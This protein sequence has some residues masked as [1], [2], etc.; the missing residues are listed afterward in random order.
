MHEGKLLCQLINHSEFENS[1]YWAGNEISGSTEGLTLKLFTKVIEKLEI[2]SFL[3][4]GAN[5]GNFGFI[6]LGA[7]ASIREI[8]F[9]EP[10]PNAF[11]VLYK[12]LNL[13]SSLISEKRRVLVLDTA[14]TDFDGVSDLYFDPRKDMQFSASLLSNFDRRNDSSIQ[15]KCSQV[16]TLIKEHS[17]LPPDL[18]KLDIEGGEIRALKGFGE[19]LYNVK[20][21]F[22]EVLDVVNAV[23]ISKL[24]SPSNYVFFD[25]DDQSRTLKVLDSVQRSSYR[26]I[27]ICRSEYRS[28]I[29]GVL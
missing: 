27:L 20:C 17:L 2:K 13:N 18:V 12:N 11:Q 10:L 16:A 9:V 25:I 15:V 23:E 14:L 26:N 5:S 8:T 4:G 1:I 24:F 29:Q 6:C 21:F 22:L 28:V 19:H 7:S 3:D